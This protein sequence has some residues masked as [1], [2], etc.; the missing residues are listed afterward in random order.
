MRIVGLDLSLTS[1]G[2][3][4]PEHA[5][6]VTIKV[7][8]AKNASE[9]QRARRLGTITKR[10]LEVCGLTGEHYF[11]RADLVVLEGYAFGAKAQREHMGEL[12]GLMKVRLMWAGVPF[13]VVPPSKLKMYATGRGNASKEEVLLAVARRAGAEITGNDV[14]DAWVLF[15][16]AAAHYSHPFRVVMPQSHD[17]ALA[18]VEWPEIGG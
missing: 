13:V 5:A 1:T 15:Q 6:G 11:P 8:I 7:P 17:R 3:Y 10:V 18:G 2:V 12:G 16:M 14:A 4:D 9:L